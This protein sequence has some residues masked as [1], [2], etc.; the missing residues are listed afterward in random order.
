MTIRS[1][2]R[3]VIACALAPTPAQRRALDATLDAFTAA[4]RQAMRVG[5]AAGTSAN[6]VIHRRCYRALRE[7]HGL[8]AN[9][10][11]RAIARAARRLKGERGAEIDLAALEQSRAWVLEDVSG[12][13]I[14]YDARTISFSAEAL[15]VSLSTVEG[16]IKS[17]RMALDAAQAWRLRGRHPTRATLMIEPGRDYWIAIELAAPA[18]RGTGAGRP[19]DDTA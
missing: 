7:R 16:R 1:P 3:R 5:R 15:T 6:A 18:L 8:S 2:D 9:L 12:S 11:V 13:S 14:D 10:A 19:T 4:C 17:V